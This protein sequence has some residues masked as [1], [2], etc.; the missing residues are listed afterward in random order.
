MSAVAVAGWQLLRQA[1]ALSTETT[2][3]A[4]AKAVVAGYFAQHIASEARGLKV[5]ALA[6]ADLLYALD[7]EALAG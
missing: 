5:Q 1:R 4:K 7:A 3:Q 2:P 6:G